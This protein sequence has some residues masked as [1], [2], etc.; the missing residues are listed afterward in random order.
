MA[1]IKEV[2]GHTPRVGEGTFV[3]E[4]AVLIGDVTVGRDSSIWFN[5]VLRGDVNSITVGDRT[6][7]QDGT[8]IHTLYDGAPHP[9]ADAYRQRRVD[10]SQRHDPRCDHRG[11]LPDRHGGHGARQRRRGVGLHRDAGALV[12]SGAK[13][14]PDSVYAGVPARKVKGRLRPNNAKR[15]SCASPATTVC[16][17]RGTRRANSCPIAN[18]PTVE[19][20]RNRRQPVDRRGHFTGGQFLLRAVARGRKE[21]RPASAFQPGVADGSGDCPRRRRRVDFARRARLSALRFAGEAFRTAM[22]PLQGWRMS[23]RRA[24][25]SISPAIRRASCGCGRATICW[26]T[27]SNRTVRADGSCWDKCWNA[28]ASRSITE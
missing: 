8:V 10:R 1:Y 18:V 23:H 7:I 9:F 26:P 11:Q 6:N 22:P 27:R 28:T 13:L 24:T 3:A 2:R 15:S 25:A 20:Q 19:I 17:P 21:R 5:T 14:E 12:L 4:T 16:T